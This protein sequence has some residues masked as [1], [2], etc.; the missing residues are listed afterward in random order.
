[1]TQTTDN[2][3]PFEAAMNAEVPT[4]PRTVF[5]EMQIDVWP[6]VLRKG[7][8]KVPFDA[9]QHSVDERRTAIDLIL[10]PTR[11][12]YNVE[13]HLIAESK[14]WAQIVKPS[15]RELGIDLRALNGRFVQA[16]L[17]PTGRTYTNAAGETKENTTFKFIKVYPDMESC[18]EAADEFFSNRG[19]ASSNGSSQA[20]PAQAQ[21]A[22]LTQQN[23]H[24]RETALKFLPALWKSA[25]GDI[26]KLAELLA[27]NPLTKKYFDI[28]SPEV[29]ALVSGQV[30]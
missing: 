27:N 18:I 15:L 5:G 10:I 8:G 2:Y 17:V 23:D 29:V 12:D 11:G 1:M 26:N 28:S 25:N 20:T 7:E 30:A 4:G 13:R 9:T 24:E 14:E 3:D 21:P 6:C 16:Q 19:A 22:A